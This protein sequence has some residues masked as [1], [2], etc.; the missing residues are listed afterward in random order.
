MSPTA[1]LFPDSSNAR[2]RLEESGLLRTEGGVTRTTRKWQS[3][4]ARAAYRLYG[5]E[6]NFDLR[7]PIG[8]ALVELFGNDVPDRD[9]AEWIHCLL[10][11]EARELDP[12]DH[13]EPVGGLEQEHLE[14]AIARVHH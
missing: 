2:A 6:Q 14:Q 13:L 5:S 1:D 3:A 12:R 9:L 7:V 10:P 11:I 4:M 8:M